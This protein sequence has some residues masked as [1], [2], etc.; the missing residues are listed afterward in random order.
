MMLMLP[1]FYSRLMSSCVV[2]NLYL[3]ELAT[4]RPIARVRPLK[5][6]N[7]KRTVTWRRAIK[8]MIVPLALKRETIV[9]MFARGAVL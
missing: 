7:R 4:I 3:A 2:L 1:T 6:L 5:A 9:P 8:Y